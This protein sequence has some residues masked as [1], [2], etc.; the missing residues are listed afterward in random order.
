M[1][2]FTNSIVRGEWDVVLNTISSLKLPETKLM[3]VCKD[4]E[5]KKKNQG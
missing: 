1:E 3:M 5:E 4:K 2:S